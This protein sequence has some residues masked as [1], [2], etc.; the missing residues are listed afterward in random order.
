MLVIIEGSNKYASSISI[1]VEEL[2]AKN[3]I[4]IFLYNTP[5]ANDFFFYVKN[6]F[7]FVKKSIDIVNM[8]AFIL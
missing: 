6:F 3:Y 1:M 7:I 2:L 4:L 5:L 8:F